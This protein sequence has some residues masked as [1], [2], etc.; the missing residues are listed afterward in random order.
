MSNQ[1]ETKKLLEYRETMNKRVQELEVEISDLRK[2][3]ATVDD[4]IVNTGFR[5]LSPPA[6]VEEKPEPKA[7]DKTEPIPQP[8]PREEEP[9]E[10]PEGISITSKDGTVLGKIIV[11]GRDL[12]Y[13][14]QPEFNF[15]SDIP[16]FQ[17][18]LLDRVLGNMKNTDQ[19]RATNGEIDASETLE[20]HVIEEEG[21]IKEI[22]I[23]N[24]G[25]E[26][27]LR[28]INSSL[29]WTFDKMYDKLQQG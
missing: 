9:M 20:F 19:E 16:P 13:K 22:F 21:K 6:K 14:P 29:R 28:E 5:T 11:E 26:R 15:K 27:R 17:S 2:A 23:S 7:E 10:T 24:Y 18:F 4:V 12:T 3:I 25:G 1:T 8:Q